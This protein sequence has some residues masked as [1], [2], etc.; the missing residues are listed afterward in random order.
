MGARDLLTQSW[1]LDDRNFASDMLASLGKMDGTWG[2]FLQHNILSHSSVLHKPHIE[3]R[4]RS[5]VATMA[6]GMAGLADVLRSVVGRK[7]LTL[8]SDGFPMSIATDFPQNIDDPTM[9]GSYL[10]D[11]LETTLGDL[12][13]SG[14]VI[15]SVDLAGVRRSD[16]RSEGLFFLANETGGTLVEGTNRLAQG[17]DGALRRSAHSYVLTVQADDVKPDGAYHTLKVRLRNAGRGVGLHHR[18]GFFAPLPFGK[19]K[20]VQRIAEAARLVAGDEEQDDLGVEVVAVPLRTGAQSTSVAVLVEIPGQRLLS[21]GTRIGLEVFGYAL[22]ERGSSSDFFAQAVELDPAKVGT[23]LARSGVR[24]LG[25]LDL[26]PGQHLLRVLVRDRGNG[27]LS[28]LSVPL[29]L[30]ETSAEPDPRLEALFLSPANDPWLLVRSAEGAFDVHGR[31]VLPAAQADLPAAGEAQLLLVGHGFT[32]KGAWVKGRILTAAGKPATGGDVE[33]LA[34]T[35]GEAGQPDLLTARL[36]TGSLPPGSY[37]L[38][39]RLGGDAGKAKAVAARR[40][41]VTAA[42]GT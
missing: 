12:R 14:W 30:D 5:H 39:L 37:L 21:S 38:E 16:D 42:P 3:A 6:E 4:Q 29:H 8:F 13:R 17:L 10:L 9:G 31:A 19:Q 11:R 22:D 41:Q 26:P 18:G 32:G 33:L 2:S 27:R 20:D 40:F 34:I 28:L 7:Y 24:V 1:R 23:R 36:R 15:H 25:N 35:P